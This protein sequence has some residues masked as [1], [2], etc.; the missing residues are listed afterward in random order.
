MASGIWDETPGSS[1]LFSA[2][3]SP[4]R[5]LARHNFHVLLAVFAGASFFTSLPFVF[6]GAWPVAGFMGIDV[7]IF[8][9]AFRASF[10]SASAYEGIEVTY[11]ELILLK[12][13]AQGEQ[14]EWRFNPAFVRLEQVLQGEY[15]AARVSLVSRGRSIEV[16][17]F[18]GPAEKK[19]FAAG[20]DKALAEA[21]RGILYL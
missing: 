8:Y 16:A 10:R 4:H 21:R 19:V 9:F 20:L 17:A 13:S 3:L 5:S 1:R 7:A 15:G 12:V 14:E 2:R 11:F 6:L 18:L